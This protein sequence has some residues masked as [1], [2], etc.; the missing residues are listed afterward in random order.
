M[1]GTVGAMYGKIQTHTLSLGVV[2]SYEVPLVVPTVLI[3]SMLV[4]QMTPSLW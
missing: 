3:W 2:V 1:G 4:N